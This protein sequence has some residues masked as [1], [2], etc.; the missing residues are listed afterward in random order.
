MSKPSRT[1]QRR[2]WGSQQQQPW[3]QQP[4][5]QLQRPQQQQWSHPQQ[6]QQSQRGGGGK[7]KG[8][9]LKQQ[10]Q[11]PSGKGSS[12]AKHV[13]STV[14]HLTALGFDDELIDEVISKSKKAQERSRTPWQVAQSLKDK[15]SN[16]SKAIAAT[17][18]DISNH[19]D[20]L[21]SKRQDLD[22]LYDQRE[23]W[24]TKLAECEGSL[25]P[26]DPTVISATVSDGFT[27]FSKWVQKFHDVMSRGAEN[28]SASQLN[29]L[30]SS[31][32]PMG[33][34]GDN[35]DEPRAT[36]Q[37]QHD[38]HMDQ[39]GFGRP[40]PLPRQG[41]GKGS[42]MRRSSSL[43]SSPRRRSRS[44]PPGAKGSA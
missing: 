9:Q 31:V 19:E 37:S 5:Q 40:L 17:E 22:S 3:Q 29:T 33:E 4:Q 34:T 20:L 11:G 28:V 18:L 10:Q 25:P 13:D 36:N 21:R 32:P 41:S 12:T 30:M 23:D 7:G 38:A 26:S 1:Q 8:Q 43:G 44:P 24:Q 14:Q 16:A 2:R 6:Q 15:I 35:D 27:K 39:D 42:A